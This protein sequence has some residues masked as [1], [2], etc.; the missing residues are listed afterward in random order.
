M[1]KPEQLQKGDRVAIIAPST[2]A[3]PNKVRRSEKGLRALGL[4]PVYYPSCFSHHGHLAGTDD[5]RLKDIH[6]AFSDTTIKGI[7]CLKGGSGATRLLDKIDYG[8]ISRHP[9]VFVGYSDITAL[10]MAFQNKC[11]LVTFHGPMA[12]SDM[13]Q[14][15]EEQQVK[16]DTFTYESYHANLFG[17][18]PLGVVDNPK[19]FPLGKLVGGKAEG[20]LVGGN[21]SLMISTLGS[22]YE[23]DT[24]GKVLFIEEVHESAYVVDRMLTALALAGKFKDCIGIILG[25]WTDCVQEEKKSYGGKDLS[26]EEIFEEVIRPWGKPTITNLYAGHNTPQLMLPFGVHV[27]IDADLGTIEFTE[28][29]YKGENNE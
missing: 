8:I 3:D 21:L 22:P 16:F 25:T 14:Y 15:D 12:L 1:V 27:K 18:G 11:G 4:E 5:I 6:D 7:I 10:H 9:K 28:S 19:E 24:K 26:L 23:I 17:T 13:Y 29:P 2:P 20:P